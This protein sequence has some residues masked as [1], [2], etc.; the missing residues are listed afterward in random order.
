MSEILEKPITDN[1]KTFLFQLFSY[2]VFVG[3]FCFMVK[4]VHQFQSK[5]IQVRQTDTSCESKHLSK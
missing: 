2:F 5:F 1:L 3:K 4:L